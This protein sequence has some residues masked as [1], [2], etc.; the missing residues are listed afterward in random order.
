MLCNSSQ[1]MLCN[2]IC[3]V[4]LYRICFSKAYLIEFLTLEF[5]FHMASKLWED[6][7]SQVEVRS[8]LCLKSHGL[9]QM[10]LVIFTMS[11]III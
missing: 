3:Y 7:L 4:N 6:F 5:G 2:N 8:I 10:L 1:V 11:V 9:D